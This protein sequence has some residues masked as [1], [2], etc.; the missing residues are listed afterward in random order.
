VNGYPASLQPES[1]MAH[2]QAICQRI[3]LRPS[4]AKQERQAA[5][6]IENTLQKLGIPY[7]QRQTFKSQN[8]SGMVTVPCF[9]AGLL[10]TIL[11]LFAGLWVK[12]IGSVLIWGS[13][14]VF[15]QALLVTPPFFERLIARWTSQNVIASA[16]AANHLSCG[17]SRQ[18]ET[19]FPVPAFALVTQSSILSP[20]LSAPS[21][22]CSLL[23]P[24]SNWRGANL[25]LRERYTIQVKTFSNS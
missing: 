23:E 2:M 11:A 15:R 16:P 21:R 22:M 19:A 7:I 1:L 18:P 9:A 17:T 12:I 10:G 13:A 14:Y 25:M 4:T 3:G 6:Y 8:S 20:R 5:D 24:F